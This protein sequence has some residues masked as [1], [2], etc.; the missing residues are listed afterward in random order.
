MALPKPEPAPVISQT[1]EDED[2]ISDVIDT[3]MNKLKASIAASNNL[4]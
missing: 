4:N 3:R 1:G 2:M